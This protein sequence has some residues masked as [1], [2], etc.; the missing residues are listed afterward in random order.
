[1][2]IQK[3]TTPRHPAIETAR[4]QTDRASVVV[5]VVVVVLEVKS[6]SHHSSLSA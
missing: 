6:Q 3:M 4:P 2:H 5:V 1:M